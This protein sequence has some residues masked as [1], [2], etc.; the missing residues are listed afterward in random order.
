MGR[1]AEVRGSGEKGHATG[2]VTVGGEKRCADGGA[3]GGGQ[4][5]RAG[6]GHDRR[7]MARALRAWV[8]AAASAST[9]AAGAWMVADARQR[10][11]AVARRVV[12]RWARGALAAG[13][14]AYR[15]R[16]SINQTTARTGSRDGGTGV[17][18]Y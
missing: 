10:Q 18:S 14:P 12:A 9:A 3:M 4:M 16:I 7:Q 11:V 2:G 5:R 13:G 6:G 17:R 15:V 8:A 1:A